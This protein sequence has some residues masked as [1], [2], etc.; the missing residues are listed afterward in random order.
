VQFSAVIFDL[1]NCLA[2]ADE[3]G[4]ELL[5]LMFAAIRRANQGRVS[6]AALE[7]AFSDSWRLPLDVV[8]GKYEF[9]DEMLAAAWDVGRQL[10]I[11]NPMIG[12][13]DLSALADLPVKQFVVTSGFRK[14]QESKIDAL[15]LRSKF[16][17]TYVDAI[18][19]SDRKGKERIFQEIVEQHRLD[20]KTV[21]VV[22]DSPESEIEAG[23]RLGMQTVQ[24]LRPGVTRGTNATHYV[25]NLRE[26]RAIIDT[27]RP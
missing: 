25:R 16:A 11:T 17:G 9:S 26:L 8:A 13:G 5:E 22:G 27:R 18:D 4:R 7:R 20:P 23:N 3:L 10:A 1:D 21:L 2:P 19:E 12:Y 14:L 24:I 6:E 15:N